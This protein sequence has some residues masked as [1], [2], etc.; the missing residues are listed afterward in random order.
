MRC[1]FTPTGA[2]RIKKQNTSVGKDGEKLE[3]LHVAEEKAKWRGC[4]EESGGSS[5][6]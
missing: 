2:A 3:S 4:R 1:Y 6:S 5:R